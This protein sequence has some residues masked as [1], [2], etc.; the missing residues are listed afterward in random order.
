MNRSVL[1]A[2]IPKE[3]KGRKKIGNKN[4]CNTAKLVILRPTLRQNT[5]NSLV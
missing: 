3:S 2:G 1:L 5:V 4:K